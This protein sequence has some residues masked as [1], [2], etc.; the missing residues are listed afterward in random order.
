MIMFTSDPKVNDSI[1]KTF[2]IRPLLIGTVSKALDR[3]CVFKSY[4]Q[5]VNVWLVYRA[6]CFVV[7]SALKEQRHSVESLTQPFR[8]YSL[9]PV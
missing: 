3:T 9:S 6:G 1:L 4:Q 7:Y 5:T 2:L 8:S